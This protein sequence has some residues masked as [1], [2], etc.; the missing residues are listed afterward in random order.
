MPFW[1]RPTP[2]PPPPPTC[3]RCGTLITGTPVRGDL[4][5]LDTRGKFYC[6]RNCHLAAFGATSPRGVI[7]KRAP[8]STAIDYDDQA[9]LAGKS[10]HSMYFD[11]GRCAKCGAALSSEYS[12]FGFCSDDC[13]KKAMRPYLPDGHDTNFSDTDQYKKFADFDF[14]DLSDGEVREIAA[15]SGLTGSLDQMRTAI[16]DKLARRRLKVEG[17]FEQD[18]HDREHAAMSQFVSKWQTERDR[19]VKTEKEKKFQRELEEQIAR[20]RPIREANAKLEVQ[21]ILDARPIPEITDRHRFEHTLIVGGSGAGKTTLIQQIILDNLTRDDPPAMVVLDPKG[22]MIDR[23]QRL[24]VFNPDDGRL[25]DR[26]V[27]VDPLQCPAINMFDPGTKRLQ[28]H[29]DMLRQQIENQAVEQFGYI[30]S[31]VGNELTEKQSIPFGFVVRLLFSME[32]ATIHTLLDVL[33]DRSKTLDQSP[34]A[35]HI[36][37]LDPISQRFFRNEFFTGQYSET[38]PQIKQRL[39]GL[40][41]RPQ[42]VEMF[43]SP[44]RKL[45]MFQCLQDRKIVLVNTA[46]GILGSEGSQVFGR[47]I[48]SLVLNAAFARIAIRN[49][50]EWYSAFLIVDEFQEFADEIKTPE[51][52]RLAREYNLGVV[53]ATQVLHGPPFTDAL[54]NSMSTNTT[55]KYA[56]AVEGTDLNYMAR[57][58]RCEPEYIMRR[59]RTDTEVD[60]ACYVRNLFTDAR[61]IKAPIGNVGSQPQMTEEQLQRL[62]RLN[63]KRLTADR[64]A[65]T[66]VPSSPSPPPQLPAKPQ[67][68]PQMGAGDPDTGSHTDPASS[69][70]KS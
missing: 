48:I 37:Q 15:E 58:M 34:F 24:A 45:D 23:L 42:F 43:S 7:Y 3:A 9:L 4:E 21:K 2:P 44:E 54:R 26:I 36:G 25:K 39:F 51:L 11:R 38:R 63:A 27:V 66:P 65:P 47:Y 53:M 13:R 67:A 68:A 14:L 8:E 50:D 61:S 41:M 60:F 49:R 22:L 19:I 1:S 10:G 69:W 52:L 40:L 62:L 29:S 33:D 30:F 70:G 64:Q 16:Y 31:S 55:I 18:K 12:P 46:S 6:S 56:A 5:H 32:G 57:D 17:K 28:L 59:R 20:D 35:P